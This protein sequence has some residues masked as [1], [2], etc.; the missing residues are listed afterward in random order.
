ML[1]PLIENDIRALLDAPASG[2][3][4]PSLAALEE[5]LTTGYARAM[6]LEA[7]LSRLQRQIATLVME[8][9]EDEDDLPDPELRQ[10]AQGLKAVDVELG[11]L[12]ALLES[13]RR[14]ADATRAAA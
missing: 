8:V 10:M 9:A 13:L 3:R 12:R 7:E 1:A 5:A 6:A 2:A 4:A 14:R 11:A